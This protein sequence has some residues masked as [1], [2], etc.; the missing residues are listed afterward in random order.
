MLRFLI[1]FLPAV[2]AFAQTL[3]PAS[4]AGCAGIDTNELRKHLAV[5]SSD[6][7]EGRETTEPGQKKAAAYIA[8]VFNRLHLEPAA[9]SGTYFQHFQVDLIYADPHS[10]ITANIHGAQKEFHWGKDFVAESVCDTI[11]SGAAAFIGFTDNEIDSAAMTKLANRIVF[12][13]MGQRED[14]N[15]SSRGTMIRRLNSM[16]HQMN[17][18]AILIIADGAGEASFSDIV[19]TVREMDPKRRTMRLTSGVT[20]GAPERLQFLVSY[21]MAEEILKSSGMT[22][23]E[24]RAKAL[25]RTAFEPV[26]LDDVVCTIRSRLVQ[27]TRGT[28]NVIGLLPGSDERLKDQVVVISAHYD[29]LGKDS[30]GRIYHGADDDGSGTST[31]LDLA[32]AFAKNPVRPKRSILFVTMVGEEK[33]LLGSRYYVSHPVIPLRQTVADL[34]IDMIGRVDPAHEALREMNYV[35][36]IGSDKISPELDSLLRVADGESERV[37][38]DYTYDADDDPEQLYRRSDHYNFA[39]HNIPVVFF[40]TGIHADYHRPTDTIDKILFD[41]M[42]RIARVICDLGWRIANL[43]HPLTKKA[44][45]E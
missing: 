35:Y 7:L 21:E 44:W 30:L 43:P 22:I 16:P 26:L 41:R 45:N 20:L 27:E 14:F 24:L 10:K 17:A 37:R 40:F 33:G 38:L 15:D 39:R 29:H 6:S 13:T 12:V 18:A 42:A 2:F 8:G 28:E 36:V 32:E 23:A 1:L 4:R 11:V 25:G 5:L 34:N 19:H 31:V 9:D 3:D